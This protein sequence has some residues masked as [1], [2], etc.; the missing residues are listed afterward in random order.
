MNKHL[1]GMNNGIHDLS[2]KVLLV[3]LEILQRIIAE[4]THRVLNYSVKSASTQ[5]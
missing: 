5:I 3:N 2:E 1:L 4:S